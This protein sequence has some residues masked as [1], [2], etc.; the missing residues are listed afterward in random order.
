MEK[1]EIIGVLAAIASFSLI[2]GM[3]GYSLNVND[4]RIIENEGYVEE[5][6]DTIWIMAYMD[7]NK[8]SCDIYK[9]NETYEIYF[10]LSDE[11]ELYSATGW[12]SEYCVTYAVLDDSN[13]YSFPEVVDSVSIKYPDL[14]EI[15]EDGFLFENIQHE[16]TLKINDGLP[17]GLKWE[18]VNTTYSNG[19]GVTV[20]GTNWSVKTQ[21]NYLGVRCPI[22]GEIICSSKEE[23]GKDE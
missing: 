5:P 2:S 4:V 16:T 14:F 7:G 17:C 20:S 19:S 15:G 21:I 9:Y 12:G 18:I 22:C 1:Y 3:I 8:L 13:P 10:P 23:F 11:Y 6:L